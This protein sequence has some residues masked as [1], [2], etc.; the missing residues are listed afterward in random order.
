MSPQ[1]T[2]DLDPEEPRSCDDCGWRGATR[3]AV[4]LFDELLTLNCPNCDARVGGMYLYP[5]GEEIREAAAAGNPRAIA[6]LSE[7][8]AREKRRHRIVEEGTPQAKPVGGRRRNA[9]FVVRWS[10]ERA[11]MTSTTSS[12]A[13]ASRSSDASWR[14]GKGCRGSR[15]SPSCSESVT[16]GASLSYVL[17]RPRP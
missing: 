9:P 1:T 12:C 10:L 4:E 5:T 14:S 11:P 6:M 2:L 13:P 3:G 7:T 8:D 16:A 17:R 15:Q